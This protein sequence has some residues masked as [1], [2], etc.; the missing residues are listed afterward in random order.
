MVEGKRL[1]LSIEPQGPFIMPR[2]FVTGA[3]DLIHGDAG[4]R[5]I[6]RLFLQVILPKL[7]VKSD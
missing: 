1:P 6:A 7:G 5:E 3:N 4:Y 2:N